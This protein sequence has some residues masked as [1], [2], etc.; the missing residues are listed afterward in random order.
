ME[1]LQGAVVSFGGVSAKHLPGESN[2]KADAELYCVSEWMMEP[3][4]FGQIVDAWGDA[5][6]TSLR[7]E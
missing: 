3:V 1:S 6:Y 7:L 4:A 2:M 5:T